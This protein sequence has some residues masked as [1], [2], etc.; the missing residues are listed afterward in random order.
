MKGLIGSLSVFLLGIASGVSF[1]HLLQRGP[2]ATLSGAQFLVVQQVLLRNYGPSIGGLEAAALLSTL[3]MAIVT[4]GEPMVPLLATIACACVLF[5]IIIWAAWI[6]PINKTV[7]SW[8]PV[9]LPSN[10]PNFRDRWHRL[11]AIRLVL[12]VVA[13][14]A[15]IAGLCAWASVHPARPMW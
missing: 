15:V 10:W 7:N 2:K 6:N 1:S 11:H 14:S 4:W 8:T 9:S 13:F 3:A 12:S 5:M